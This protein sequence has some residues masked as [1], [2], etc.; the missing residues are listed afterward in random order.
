MH[1]VDICLRQIDEVRQVA[2]GVEVAYVG[3]SR[4]GR[5]ILN[6]TRLAANQIGVH[7]PDRPVQMEAPANASASGQAVI[8]CCNRIL[9]ITKTISQ[10]SEPLDK[11][12]RSGWST[13]LIELD[14]LE[15]HLKVFK[16]SS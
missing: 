4:I 5:L 15:R 1:A 2:D 13:L 11:R 3:R 9:D 14:D 12:W 6:V 7:L 8:A 16:V 10:P